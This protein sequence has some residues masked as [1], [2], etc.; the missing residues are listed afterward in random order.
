MSPGMSLQRD[1]LTHRVC[2]PHPH[3]MDVIQNVPDLDRQRRRL[4]L[5]A[6]LAAARAARERSVRV[7]AVRVQEL[8]AVRRRLMGDASL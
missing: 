6:A 1:L 7:R 8:I 2:G 4:R 5:L 3:P